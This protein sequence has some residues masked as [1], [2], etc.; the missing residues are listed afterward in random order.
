ML[1]ILFLRVMFTMLE[2]YGW[3]LYIKY[4]MLGMRFNLLTISFIKYSVDKYL[5]IELRI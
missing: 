4:K 1:V 3:F 2:Y 5:I